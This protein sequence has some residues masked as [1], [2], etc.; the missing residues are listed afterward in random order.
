MGEGAPV[1]KRGDRR[2]ENYHP[3]TFLTAVDK[4]F[5]QLLSRQVICHYDKTLYFKMT[6]YRK[7]L[8]WTDH[9]LLNV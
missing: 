1:F 6:A 2:D 3:I 5:Q 4:I 7:K 8:A 9:G